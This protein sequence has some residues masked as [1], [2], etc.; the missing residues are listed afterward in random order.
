[1][2]PA[3]CNSARVGAARR[4]VAAAGDAGVARRRAQRGDA[5]AVVRD[6]APDAHAD[7]RR[8]VAAGLRRRAVGGVGGGAG[9][10]WAVTD[11]RRGLRITRKPVLDSGQ[12]QAR[13]AA[14][15][16]P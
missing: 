8:G 4:T 9:R 10:G 2:L 11:A 1:M 14:N 13:I 7:A 15:R 5:A 3:T 6:Q 12:K 16:A